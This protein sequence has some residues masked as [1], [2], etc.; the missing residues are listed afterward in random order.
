MTTSAA[1][2][3]V[4]LRSPAEIVDAVPHLVGFH[5]VN[6][7]VFI[8]LRGKRRRLGVV[9]RFDLPAPTSSVACADGVARYLAHDRATS[10]VIVFYPPSEGPAHPAVRAI[11]DAMRERLSAANMGLTEM[12]C[13]S[14]GRWWSLSCDDAQCCPPEGTPVEAD[15]ASALAAAMAVNGR[16]TLASRDEL[17]RTLEPVGG[18]L[19]TAMSQ[20]LPR[21]RAELAQRLAEGGRGEVVAESIAL[22][23]AA[24]EARL[25]DGR[26]R[27]FD[28]DAA[29]RLI[30]G[31]DDT[32]VRDEIITWFDGEWGD[33]TRAVMG[34]LVRQAVPPFDATPLTVFAWLAYLGGSGALANIA[35]D[36][37]F[38]QGT[39]GQGTGTPGNGIEGNGMAR[40]LDDALSA[41][42]N[43]SRFKPGLRAVRRM[44]LDAESA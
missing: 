21:A 38:G 7:V 24:V 44:P 39:S 20:A 12:L 41:G 36:R 18:L 4:K 42:V 31:L 40:L 13:V 37:V 6:S 43:P 28:V 26:P 9:G 11:A 8:A 23:Y 25:T 35:L 16:V 27:A 14:E 29:T 19:A 17:A 1:S 34:E 5:P 15:A 32:S 22:L 30:V 10:S 33:A 2:Q 3:P